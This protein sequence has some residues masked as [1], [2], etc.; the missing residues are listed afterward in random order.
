VLT[1]RLDELA[2]REPWATAVEAVRAT[3]RSAWPAEAEC[4]ED[5]TGRTWEVTAYRAETTSAADERVILALRDVTRIVALQESLRKSE[6]M[7]VMGSLVAGVAHEVRNPLFGISATVD[8][9]ECGQDEPDGLGLLRSEVARLSRLMQDLLDYGKPPALSLAP[10]EIA[11]IL[12]AAIRACAAEAREKDVVAFLDVAPD[13]PPL[14]VDGARMEQVFLNLVA[15]AIHYSPR[16]GQVRVGAFRAGSFDDAVDLLVEDEGPGLTPAD[17]PRLFEP[18]FTRREGGTGLGLSIVQRIVEAHG[19]VVAAANRPS[20]G[21]AFRVRLPM[22]AAPQTMSLGVRG[23]S[24]VLR[25]H[26]DREVF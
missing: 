13:V 14:V 9:L 12:D 26:S 17:L 5:D 4:T 16:G 20:G 19:G 7:S 2:V 8:V 23:R 3:G 25:D 11:S 22:A 1:L 6:T 18:F 24:A 15:N 21:A 10:A